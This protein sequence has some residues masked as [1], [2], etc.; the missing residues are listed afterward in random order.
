MPE[1]TATA[2][3]APAKKK[4]RKKKKKIDKR[5]PK[6]KAAQRVGKKRRLAAATKKLQKPTAKRKA[7]ANAL[8]SVFHSLDKLNDKDLK[9]VIKYTNAELKKRKIGASG[10]ANAG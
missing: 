2:A 7:A 3:P 9:S 1:V 4:A 6:Q 5:T 8:V 10:A